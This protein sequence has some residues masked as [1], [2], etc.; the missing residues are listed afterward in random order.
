MEHGV[1][2][3]RSP[4]GTT[5]ALNLALSCRPFGTQRDN[6][7]QN[8]GLTSVATTCRPVGTE[9]HARSTLIIHEPSLL[10][11][12]Y[13]SRNIL[14]LSQKIAPGSSNSAWRSRQ[15][16]VT[17]SLVGPAGCRNRL[18]RH[19]F[20]LQACYRTD[21]ADGRRSGRIVFCVVLWQI[22]IRQLAVAPLV[23]CSGQERSHHRMT[24]TD[25][26]WVTLQ[27]KQPTDRAFLRRHQLPSPGV[28]DRV[29]FCDRTQHV[30]KQKTFIE[31][32]PIDAQ[33][34]GALKVSVSGASHQT[35]YCRNQID[36]FERIVIPAM[37]QNLRF[38]HIYCVRSSR[39]VKCSCVL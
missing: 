7:T 4:R 3:P 29:S 39:R 18:R 37:A 36:V 11:A 35:Q 34:V 10:S 20:E 5:G 17:N 33:C 25:V 24:F 28:L 15:S 32:Q 31:R 30:S 14:V 22:V 38:R 19:V 12:P 6:R 27:I 26:S 2:I 8:H 1:D 16:F 21:L 23:K 13:P 9:S